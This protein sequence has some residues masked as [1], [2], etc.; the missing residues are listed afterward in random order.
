MRPDGELIYSAKSIGEKHSFTI[1]NAVLW[2]A[3]QPRLYQFVLVCGG[4][5]ICQEIGLRK[6]E[7]AKNCALL[8][9]GVPV[10]LKGVNRHGIRTP[11]WAYDAVRPYGA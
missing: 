4:E 5:Y 10:K 9:N 11:S 2:N 8:I 6:I 3:E 1:E 7:V